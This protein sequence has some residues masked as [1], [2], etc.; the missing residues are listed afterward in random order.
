MALFTVRVI[1]AR[2]KHLLMMMTVGEKKRKGKKK[3]NKD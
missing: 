2:R 3:G 1:K